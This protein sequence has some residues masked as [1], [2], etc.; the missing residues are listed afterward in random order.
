[1]CLAIPM[2]LVE[3]TEF[4]GIV[5]LDGVRRRVSLM[6][7]PDAEVGDHVLVHTGYAIGKVDEGEAAE[8]L[9]LFRRYA[10]E[11]I[12]RFGETPGSEPGDEP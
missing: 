8:I 2:K 11:G 5:E 1:M 12:H 3:R 10:D 4:E 7:L 9:E 6:L